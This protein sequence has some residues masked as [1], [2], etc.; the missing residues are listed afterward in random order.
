MKEKGNTT[1]IMLFVF[2]F[3][4]LSPLCFLS[5]SGFVYD[6]YMFCLYLLCD[7][8]QLFCVVLSLLNNFF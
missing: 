4:L 3:T 2:C 5:L 6:F 7:K 8:E 1:K